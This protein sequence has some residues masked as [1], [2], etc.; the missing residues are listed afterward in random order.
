M[1]LH[2]ATRCSVFY[3]INKILHNAANTTY[4]MFRGRAF[5][6][7]CDSSHFTV[8]HFMY[9]LYCNTSHN[10]ECHCEEASQSH[11]ICFHIKGREEMGV[12]NPGLD[13]RKMPGVQ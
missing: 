2:S 8:K 10:F 6:P 1:F 7:A 12:G 9:F 13:H 4:P 11:C 5:H 3:L